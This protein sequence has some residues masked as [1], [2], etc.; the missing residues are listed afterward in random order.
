MFLNDSQLLCATAN[1]HTLYV[2]VEY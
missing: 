2:E 1:A